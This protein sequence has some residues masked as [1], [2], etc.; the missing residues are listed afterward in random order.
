MPKPWEMT[1]EQARAEAATLRDEL[2]EADRVAAPLFSRFLDHHPTFFAECSE[3]A[4]LFYEIRESSNDDP[5]PSNRT[6]TPPSEPR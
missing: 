4:A 1:N 6:D 2:R 5:E 3:D